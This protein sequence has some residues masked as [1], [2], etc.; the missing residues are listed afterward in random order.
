MDRY[1]GHKLPVLLYRHPFQIALGVSLAI[2]GARNLIQAHTQPESISAL[3]AWL[4][5][6]YGV[7]LIVGGVSMTLGLIISARTTWGHVL[8]QVG[9]WI[10]AAGLTAYAIGLALAVALSPRA[11]M[12]IIILLALAAAC[13]IR[14]WAAILDARYSLQGIRAEVHRRNGGG[15]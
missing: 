7:A 14:S 10:A 1:R 2:I 11:S 6:G 13:V 5:H 12:V 15:H 8:E 3:P 9:L 4:S